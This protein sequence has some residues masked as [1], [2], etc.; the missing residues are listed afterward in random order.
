M[1][2]ERDRINRYNAYHDGSA[3]R[4]LSVMPLPGEDTYAPRKR[5]VRKKAGKAESRKNVKMLFLVLGVSAVLF[6]LC[7]QYLGVRGIHSGKAS[8]VASLQNE[9]KELT[10]SNDELEDDLNTNIDYKQ[11]YETVTNDYGMVYP[12]EGQ[13]RTYSS[14]GEGYARQ[15]KK[16]PG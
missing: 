12:G 13:I 8:E 4:D 15:Y 6:I 9:L 7:A 5:I 10:L 2:Q 1:S 16:I 14:G 11:I 3:A